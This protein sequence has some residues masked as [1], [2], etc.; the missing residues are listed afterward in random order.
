MDMEPGRAG[1]SHRGG[2]RTAELFDKEH[3]GWM[4]LQPLFPED[5]V[6]VAGWRAYGIPWI[7]SSESFVSLAC[8][9]LLG[10]VSA[11]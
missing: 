5:Q 10:L 7:C 4:E 2:I 11:G 8:G 6:S 3:L 1:H 9:S